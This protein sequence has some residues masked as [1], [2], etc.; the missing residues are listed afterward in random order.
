[1]QAMELTGQGQSPRST[2]EVSVRLSGSHLA[3]SPSLSVFIRKTEIRTSPHW[4]VLWIK[5]N[6]IIHRVPDM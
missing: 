3:T 4:D 1:M 6:N 5:E 2:A